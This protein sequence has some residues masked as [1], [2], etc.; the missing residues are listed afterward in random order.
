[1][2]NTPILSVCS[3]A[4]SCALSCA[5][6]CATALAEA[7][8]T[9][10]PQGAAAGETFG[11]WTLRCGDLPAGGGERAC[12]VDLWITPP[13]QKN[14]IAQLAFG[15]Q[16]KAADKT[17]QPPA[18]KETAGPKGPAGDKDA[19]VAADKTEGAAK[20]A[21]KAVA[22]A[23]KND[24]APFDADAARL[25]VL[26]PVNV[27]I[28]YGVVIATDAFTH[29]S[30]PL[31]TCVQAACFAEMELTGEQMQ[32]FRNKIRPGQLVYVDP[33]G[34]PV[35]VEFSFKG[36]DEALDLLAKR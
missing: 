8:A 16:V 13:G 6:G 31:K 11:D 19:K 2:Q 30:L 3:L 12:E 14:P 21:D 26:I 20:P 29:I 7:R 10:G 4:L 24:A 32:Q 9:M 23:G 18:A 25:I 1:M 5:L 27:T 15:R 35:T 36:L 28:A 22:D 17:A 33:A 34:Q